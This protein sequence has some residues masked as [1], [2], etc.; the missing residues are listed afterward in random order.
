MPTDILIDHKKRIV[1]LGR[2]KEVN[3]NNA[4]ILWRCNEDGT[5][6]LTFNGSG[7]AAFYDIVSIGEKYYGSSMLID[8]N[9]RI[10]ITGFRQFDS[11]NKENM[12]ILCVKED[13]NLD[14]D[15]N[16]CGYID[17]NELTDE[18]D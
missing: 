1:V 4:I 6:D 10:F 15:F 8:S 3:G 18:R 11:G 2:G 13:G 7:V 5:L 9:N 12:I 16:G 17:F 14:T